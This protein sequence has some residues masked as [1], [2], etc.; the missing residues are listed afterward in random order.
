MKKTKIVF[1]TITLL[2]L[3]LCFLGCDS[4]VS[5]NN[6]TSQPQ[7]E[8]TNGTG[9]TSG[10]DTTESADNSKTLGTLYKTQK[11]ASSTIC[12]VL[13]YD[14]NTAKSY[15]DSDLYTIES[16]YFYEG[17][18]FRIKCQTFKYNGTGGDQFDYDFRL[19]MSDQIPGAYGL[20]SYS[21]NGNTITL[22]GRYDVV[23]VDNSYR[24]REDNEA[25]LLTLTGTISDDYNSITVDGT[26]QIKMR[27]QFYPT[28]VYSD[29]ENQ[30]Y[31]VHFVFKKQ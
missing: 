25:L 1:F 10:T 7:P 8:N 23:S 5:D 17:N 15:S 13:L 18:K 26:A 27:T 9:E 12:H 29:T 19:G 3:L 2:S 20:G 22:T 30:E 21:I 6:Q 28:L 24:T 11:D 4:P 16:L 14:V 31:P